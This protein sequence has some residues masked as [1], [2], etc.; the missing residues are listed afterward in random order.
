MKIS[1]STLGCPD[2]SL[3]QAIDYAAETGFDGI[4]IR[5]IKEHLR[6]DEIYELSDEKRES[7]LLYAKE[8]GI[9]F[10]CLDASAS[11]HEKEKR[12]ENMEEAISTIKTA[13][14]CKIPYIRVF[15]NNLTRF[16]KEELLKDIASQL[17]IL[18]NEAESL[19]V[20]VLLEVHGDFNTSK[21]LLKT[22]DYVSSDKFG[23]IWD[24]DHLAK[25]EV[26]EEFWKNTK[27]LVHHI[28]LKDRTN[29]GLCSFGKG[30]LSVESIVRMLNEDNYCGF[31]SL[32]W[33]KRWH[34]ELSDAREE[35]ASF[36]NKM[37]YIL[38]KG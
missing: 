32:E 36:I 31:C 21:I 37:N 11:F 2:W 16:G 27:H 7:T 12:Q 17:R 13:A 8:K 3:K 22:A 14:L 15:G 1:F 18:C 20:K 9:D 38:N 26:P 25:N 10:C 33:E 5:G 30:I 24:I 35:F 23:I 4:E 29:E 6:A 28:H 19:G 34:P